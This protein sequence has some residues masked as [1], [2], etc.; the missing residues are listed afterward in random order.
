MVFLSFMWANLG[1]KCSHIISVHHFE[2][3]LFSIA[4]I[5][6]KNTPSTTT[7]HILSPHC[8]LAGL[9]LSSGPEVPPAAYF[10]L[11]FFYFLFWSQTMGHCK[12]VLPLRRDSKKYSETR[13]LGKPQHAE[14]LQGFWNLIPWGLKIV[15]IWFSLLF[16]WVIFLSL[17]TYCSI[18]TQTS[19]IPPLSEC[20]TQICY[21][22]MPS[23]SVIMYSTCYLIHKYTWY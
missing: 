16:A 19:D 10:F 12:P 4:G 5:L 8:R 15:G 9:A 6:L 2:K 11:S 18:H 1:N 13:N 14:Y 22:S 3:V 17:P 21:F 20:F 7:P 23:L